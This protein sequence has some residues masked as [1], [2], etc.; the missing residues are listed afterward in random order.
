MGRLS[1]FAVVFV[2]SSTAVASA[3]RQ[4]AALGSVYRV[5]LISGEALPSY[6]EP[7]P[8]E[9]RVIFTLV[10]GHE[11][12]SP[13]L[14]VISLPSA[15]VDLARTVRYTEAM[16]AAR[17]AATR[18]EAEYVAISAE[19]AQSL[20][21]LTGI[22][23]RRRRLDLAVEARR[24][25]LEW[26][27]QHFSYRAEDI[28]VLAEQFDDVINQMRIAVGDPTLSFELVSMPAPNRD[29]LMGEPSAFEATQLALAAADAADSADDRFAIL[30]AAAPGAGIIADIVKVRLEAELRVTRAY[31]DLSDRLLRRAEQQRQQANVAAIEGLETELREA[32]RRLGHERPAAVRT[33]QQQLR[34]M[35]ESASVFRL[36]LAVFDR[37]RDALSAYARQVRP[38]MERFQ[39]QQPIMTGL[40]AMGDVSQLEARRA[41]GEILR[42]QTELGRLKAPE[43]VAV[44]QSTFASALA[45][46]AEATSRRASA[47][48]IQLATAREAA[49]AAAGAVLLSSQAEQ[50]LTLRL[51]RPTLQ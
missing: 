47:P 14:Q 21:Q 11:G 15:K 3:T 8:L 4:I 17:Y 49:A 39:L 42:V 9:D 37:Q 40:R 33:L 43:S 26:S 16:R 10:A 24:R 6:G 44:V 29:K 36:A 31:A 7:A 5:F 41:G 13:T 48:E 38:L 35:R 30:R 18:G 51:K 25:L 20:D 28:Q 1:A 45:M 19:V 46:A 34:E 50:D 2:L 12:G 32:D 22:A 27:R 23:D